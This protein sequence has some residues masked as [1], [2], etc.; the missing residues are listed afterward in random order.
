M[1]EKCG[2]KSKMSLQWI[3]AK[4]KGCCSLSPCWII[5]RV[6]RPLRVIM[7]RKNS[8]A[9]LCE[10][11]C[12][13]KKSSAVL[14]HFRKQLFIEQLIITVGMY[15]FLRSVDSTPC[16]VT[17][18]RQCHTKTPTTSF[19]I[20]FLFKKLITARTATTLFNRPSLSPSAKQRT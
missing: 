12:D 8:T 7:R 18:S 6:E 4:T 19:M 16:H 9:D 2:N 13:S 15:D 11:G 1:S 3:W 5:H 14:M 10:P 17:R 20:S